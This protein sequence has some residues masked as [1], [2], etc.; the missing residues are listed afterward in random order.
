MLR[1][2][3]SFLLLW[4][5][6]C[7][8]RRSTD[9]VVSSGADA[10]AGTL[11]VR[12]HVGLVGGPATLRVR[13]VLTNV[14]HRLIRVGSNPCSSL[15]F[16][17]YHTGEHSGPPAF[18]SRAVAVRDVHGR[19][20][21]GLHGRP[22]TAKT[23]VVVLSPGDSMALEDTSAITTILG[24]SL[25]SSRYSVMAHVNVDVDSVRVD[26]LVPAG[27]IDSP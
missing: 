10:T 23:T 8:P 17:L 20:A 22:C 12:A 4:L 11:G 5:S 13:A 9:G 27:Q 18:D 14:A 26:T 15:S 7:H 2:A 24:D 21:P 1:F 16:Q 6:A 3:V 19:I 25:E